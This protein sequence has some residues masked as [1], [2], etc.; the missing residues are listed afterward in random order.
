[1]WDAR[2]QL[3]WAAQIPAGVGRTLIPPRADDSH[4]AFTWAD[5]ALW[6]E[7]VGGKRAGIRLRQVNEARGLGVLNGAARS[8]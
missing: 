7:P 2:V 3:H 6:Q 1:M 4:T 5:G 8:Y